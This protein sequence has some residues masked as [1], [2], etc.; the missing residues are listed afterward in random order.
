VEVEVNQQVVKLD[1]LS[2]E[3]YSKGKHKGEPENVEEEPAIV[4]ITPFS[5][6]REVLQEIKEDLQIS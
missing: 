5:L 1:V 3:R 4:K 2:I 6:C